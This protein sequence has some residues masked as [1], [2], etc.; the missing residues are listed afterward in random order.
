MGA[1]ALMSLSQP[2]AYLPFFSAAC[3]T[4]V[5]SVFWSSTSAPW[6]ISDWAASV[7]LGG[8][9]QELIQTTLV[10]TFGFTDWAPRVK[11]LMLRSTSGIGNEATKP[12]TLLLVIPPA[13][14]PAR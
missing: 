1:K 5:E 10:L 13:T 9:N 3:S 4:A 8:S 2:K 12:R 14:M 7:S 11:A 6:F